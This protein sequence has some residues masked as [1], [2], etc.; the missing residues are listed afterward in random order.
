[1]MI[2][3]FFF[4]E[5]P[6]KWDC[7]VQMQKDELYEYLGY[8]NSNLKTIDSTNQAD[9]KNVSEGSIILAPN[10]S[11]QDE[12]R[13]L[14]MDLPPDIREELKHEQIGFSAQALRADVDYEREHNQHC[15]NGVYTENADIKELALRAGLKD[16]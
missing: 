2:K 9:F 15:D 7:F 1:M 6:E 4:T 11:S 12:D 10:N 8:T 13:T 3:E 5:D 14:F 16:K